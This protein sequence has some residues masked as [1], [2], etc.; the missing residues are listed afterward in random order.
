MTVLYH[1][2]LVSVRRLLIGCEM[3]RFCLMSRDWK[4][5][6][7]CLVYIDCYFSSVFVVLPFSVLSTHYFSLCCRCLASRMLHKLIALK[8]CISA[9]LSLL[10]SSHARNIS[11][12]SLTI[13]IGR[14]VSWFCQGTTTFYLFVLCRFLMPAFLIDSH[15]KWTSN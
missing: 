7:S 15:T 2:C 5:F 6:G 8:N 13:S 12:W 3:D 14:H 11:F 10:D 9:C 1:L 4:V